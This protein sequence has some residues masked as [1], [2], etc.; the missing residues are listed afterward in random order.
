MVD[1]RGGAMHSCRHGGVRVIVPPGQAVMPTRITCKLVRKER[2][3]HPPPLMDSEA[4]ASRILEIGPAGV[5][6]LGLASNYTIVSH[7]SQCVISIVIE[8]FY[9]FI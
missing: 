4:L 3:L 9:L 5:S 6:L 8:Q 1:A 2:L 7:V